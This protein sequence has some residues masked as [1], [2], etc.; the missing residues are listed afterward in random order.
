MTEIDTRVGELL[1]EMTIDEKAALTAGGGMFTLA[2]VE[3]LGV[4]AWPVT[5]GPNGARGASLLG[6]GEAV[7]LCVPCGT[8]LGATF[9]PDLVEEV[10]RALGAESRTKQAAFLLAPTVNLHRSPRA[11]R[12][13]ECYAEDPVLSG[14][15]AAGFVRGVQSKGVGVTVKH[16]VGNEAETERY[17]T[18]SVIDE[19][20]LRELYLRPFEIA[21][22]EGG[23]LGIMTAYNRVNGDYVNADHRLVTGILRGEWGFEGLVMTDWFAAVATVDGSAA[24]VD[25]EMPGGG[26]SYGANLAEAVRDGRVDEATVDAMAGRILGVLARL[27]LLDRTPGEEENIADPEHAKLAVRAAAAGAVLLKNDPAPGPDGG[28]SAPILPLDPASAATVA[29]IGPNAHR[30]QLM[31]GG[32]AALRPQYRRAPVDSLREALGPGVEVTTA[33]GG[34]IDRAATTMLVPTV[35][36]P[37]GT[38]QPVFEIVDGLDPSGP[39]VHTGSLDQTKIV[40]GDAPAG[41]GPDGYSARLRGTY[42]PP[43]GGTHTFVM[44]LID[45]ARFT[46]DGQV[47]C[48]GYGVELARGD[49]FFGSGKV[50]VTG[51]AELDAGAS[52][53]FEL[54]MSAKPGLMGAV[55]LGVRLPTDDDPIAE[56]VAA[57]AE[58]DVA[59]VVVG[60]NDEWESEGFDRTTIDLPG[61]QDELVE[62][63]VAANPRTVVVLNTGGPVHL[64]WRDRVPAI[65]Q[66]WFAGQGLAEALADVLT[67]DREPGG[68][69]PVTFPVREEHAPSHGN[70]PGSNG[71]VRYGEGVF[72]GHRW[73]QERHLPMAFPFGHGLSYTR[74]GFGDPTASADRLDDP[75]ATVTVSVEVTNTGDRSG[76]QV[77]QGYVAPPPPAD[78]TVTTSRPPRPPLTL[79]AL[80]KVTLEPGE[81]AT[82]DLAFPAR[83]FAR[84]HDPDPAWAQSVI[85]RAAS[86]RMFEIPEMDAEPGWVVDAG[87]HEIVMATSSVDEVARLGVEVDE[88][89]RLL[90]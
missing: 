2:G 19:R 79:Q 66:M 63:V 67:G 50:P 33:R 76:S 8:A 68:R 25:L 11:G 20:T 29:L 58:A 89:L 70:F 88:Q 41:T 15:I 51:T 62:R 75:D 57:A 65:L 55:D 82:V 83:A 54:V 28:G 87:R 12:N 49:S 10:G 39:A 47:V 18:D 60:T 86:L 73:Y 45:E 35:T 16:F 53:P 90:R 61:R 52:Y 59:V 31:G 84:W 7:A 43:V 72:I 17:T 22:K 23:A 14:R 48:E 40:F 85:A 3:R 30:P 32:S 78:P 1:A 77:V 21:V 24:G 27:G 69:L 9:D 46:L 5:D 71:V 36:G 26:P 13:F 37:D 38:G 4:P 80:A 74:W 42:T 56:A 34:S 64:P 44:N 6:T 81:S